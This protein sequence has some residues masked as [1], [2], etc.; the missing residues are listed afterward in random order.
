MMHPI[1]TAELSNRDALEIDMKKRVKLTASLTA[2]AVLALA[3]AASQAARS[4]RPLPDF[5]VFVDPPTGFVFVKLPA[6]W[7][8]VGTVETTAAAWPLAVVTDL[9]QGE[10]DVDA[11]RTAAVA[12]TR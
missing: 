11:A 10:D 5:T 6:G 8:F 7:R 9:L 1:D 2:V 12:E 3:P 4:A